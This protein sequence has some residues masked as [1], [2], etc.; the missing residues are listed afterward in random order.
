M[1]KVVTRGGGFMFNSELDTNLRYQ[2]GYHGDF[3][4]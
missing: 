4:L 2:P 1:S 3:F